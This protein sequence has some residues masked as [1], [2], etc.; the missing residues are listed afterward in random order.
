MTARDR[1]CDSVT[2]QETLPPPLSPILYADDPWL[3]M[4]VG[5]RGMA[6]IP[7]EGLKS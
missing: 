4:L 2:L 6:N 5:I 1:L 3:S 7:L